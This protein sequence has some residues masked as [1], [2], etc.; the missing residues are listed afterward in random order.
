[1]KKPERLTVQ[2]VEDKITS[3]MI[4]AAYTVATA[5][6]YV[7]LITPIVRK[8]QVRALEELRFPVE[9]TTDIILDPQ[10]AYL[11]SDKDFSD[12]LSRSQTYK[13]AE[14]LTAST[15]EFCPLLEAEELMREAKRELVRVTKPLHGMEEADWRYIAVPKLRTIQDMLMKLII[16]IA[17]RR[18]VKSKIR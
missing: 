18:K 9:G 8:C 11:M 1:M 10:S 2:E 3:Q 6:A 17:E 5:I 13:L 16:P 7:E 4:E 15:V 14:G 12:Y